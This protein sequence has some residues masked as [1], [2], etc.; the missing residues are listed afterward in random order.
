MVNKYR[1]EKF[2]TDAN[3]AK[4]IGF[5]GYGTLMGATAAL[6]YIFIDR[7][8]SQKQIIHCKEIIQNNTKAFSGFREY[9]L[10]LATLLTLEED[11]EGAFKCISDIYYKLHATGF[12]RNSY[13]AY[14]SIGIYLNRD[15]ISIDTVISNM[16]EGYKKMNSY[17]P[18][19]TS[20]DDY[21]AVSIIA[22]N[23]KNIEADS[24]LI[25]ECYKYLNNNGFF[26]GNNLQSLANLLILSDG[27]PEERCEKVIALDRALRN[28]SHKLNG[29]YMP[30]LSILSTIT[31]DY[32][33]LA[34]DIAETEELLKSHKGF[35]TFSIE[36]TA[37]TM[38]AS[39]I[40]AADYLSENFIDSAV[41]STIN[42]AIINVIIAVE[43]AAASAAAAA[44]AAASSSS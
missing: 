44:A 29:F 23:S 35:G 1:V 9:I 17:H 3:A 40:V 30:M 15:T 26:K 37:R 25:E 8:I 38:F 31:N 19:L 22:M 20:S 5:F 28:E 7:D 13:L 18:F 42:T 14:A 12:Y 2:V 34:K 27:T 32:K 21:S 16:V 33:T 10:P 4:S 41:T 36:K 11:A 24:E 39:V 6:P 43:I